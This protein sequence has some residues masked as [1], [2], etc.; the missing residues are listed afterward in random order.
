M[1][2]LYFELWVDAIVNAKDYKMNA[3]GWKSSTL[4]LLTTANALNVMLVL[5]WLDFFKIYKHNFFFNFHSDSFAVGLLEI[6][7]NVFAP[8]GIINYFLIFFRDRYKRLMS[9]HTHYNGKLALYYSLTSI[10]LIVVTVIFVT[11]RA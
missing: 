11:V 8:I 1:K 9:R 3:P 5:L 10:F 7:F 2:N 4:W 6:F